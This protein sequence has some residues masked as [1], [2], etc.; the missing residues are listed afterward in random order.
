MRVIWEIAKPQL[1]PHIE[2]MKH[3]AVKA[4]QILS[5]YEKLLE[6][7]LIAC[8]SDDWLGRE[9]DLE[10]VQHCFGKSPVCS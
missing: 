6:D 3:W 4:L 1:N 9:Q 8:V 2:R 7:H 10:S 5:P